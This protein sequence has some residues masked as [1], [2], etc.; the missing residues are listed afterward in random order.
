MRGRILVFALSVAG[1]ASAHIALKSPTA[2]TNDQVQ[3]KVGPCGQNVNAR[4][5]NVTA[6]K[7]GQTITVAWDETIN[8]P[9]HYRI[10]FDPTGTN[11]PN[12]V[13]FTDFNSGATDLV[14][15]IPDKTGTAPIAYT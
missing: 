4:T 3:L 11:F 9:G 15:N 13:S 12:P 10:S 2:R 1:V 6:F 14:D 5:N 7:P 8:H